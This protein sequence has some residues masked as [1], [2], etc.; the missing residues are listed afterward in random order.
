M[1]ELQHWGSNSNII[2]DHINHD[3]GADQQFF[4]FLLYR[5]SSDIRFIYI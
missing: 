3:K 4:L 5:Y 1:Y 2:K